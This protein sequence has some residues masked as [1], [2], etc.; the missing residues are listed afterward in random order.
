M[1][2]YYSWQVAWEDGE[3]QQGGKYKYPHTAWQGMIRFLKNCLEYGSR[4]P[5]EKMTAAILASDGD[6]VYQFYKYTVSNFIQRRHPVL[7]KE[8]KTMPP[9]TTKNPEGITWRVVYTIA[10]ISGRMDFGGDFAAAEEFFQATIRGMK[11]SPNL[12]DRAVL[13][14]INKQKWTT[15]QDPYKFAIVSPHGVISRYAPYA[16]RTWEDAERIVEKL[17]GQRKIRYARER[18]VTQ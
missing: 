16:P 15:Y 17:R 12:D 14:R 5:D 8:V 18:E 2:T 6:V 1:T 13:Y 3:I 7:R 4:R 9:S 11:E 10:G